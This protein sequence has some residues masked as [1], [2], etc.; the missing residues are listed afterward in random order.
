M[1]K[2]KKDQWTGQVSYTLSR[3]RRVDQVN[4]EYD[5]EYDQTHNL[6]LIGSYEFGG[7]WKVSSR[8]RY[9]TGN[10]ETPV[11]GSV[12]DADNETYFPIRGPIYSTRNN[13]FSQLDLRIDKKIISDQEIWT[14]YIDIQNVLNTKNS[15]G[16]QYSY[17]YSSKQDV[18]GVPVIPAIGVRGEF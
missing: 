18:E 14:F 9:V 6:N 5:F 7:Y 12:Y 4:G 1:L 16:V 13:P 15:E 11:I 8:Y 17:D 2:Y 3:S 10:P